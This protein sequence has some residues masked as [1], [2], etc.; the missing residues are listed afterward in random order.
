VA[1]EFDTDENNDGVIDLFKF[2]DISAT[3]I[4]YSG[5]YAE[6]ASAALST[7]TAKIVDR[8]TLSDFTAET[9][10]G[11]LEIL[12]PEHD[13]GA[14][15]GITICLPKAVSVGV[16]RFDL[17]RQ[18]GATTGIMLSDGKGHTA[19]YGGLGDKVAW[20]CWETVS[21]D[22][23]EFL[24][25]N[26]DLECVREIGIYLRS[27]KGGA[28]YIDN[29]CYETL[30]NVGDISYDAEKKTL[31]WDK[32]YG[33]TEYVVKQDGTELYRGAET[34]VILSEALDK[35]DAITC[36]VTLEAIGGEASKSKDYTLNFFGEIGAISM[37]KDTMLVYWDAVE[38]ATGYTLYLNDEEAYNGT[39]NRYQVEQGGEIIKD[40][41]AKLVVHRGE[42]EKEKTAFV[43]CLHGE[44]QSFKESVAGSENKCYIA[45]WHNLA[46]WGQFD[47]NGYSGGAE[48]G[49]TLSTG[50]WKVYTGGD[51]HTRIK[52][53]F[54]HIFSTGGWGDGRL[55]FNLPRALNVREIGSI[56]FRIKFVASEGTTWSND[57]K[58]RF[59][60]NGTGVY[61][62]GSK[63]ENVTCVQDGEWAV[64]TI[65][66]SVLSANGI[67][68]IT[69][70]SV[71]SN[72]G[73]EMDI[74]EVTYIKAS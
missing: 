72:N 23:T 30:G 48:N 57:G 10:D 13:K 32:V 5:E 4:V 58:P 8:T 22:I 68:D 3:E 36:T 50:S 45:E 7:A 24:K 29:L 17:N 12:A 26:P 65:S 47:S 41:V 61:I 46:A 70:I 67:T 9:T 39:E 49:V 34:S 54:L 28:H 16:L 37:D 44:E 62:D 56:S 73:Y 64:Y 27:T 55:T 51:M 40:W 19:Y 14:M 74:Q 69:D 25:N 42:A 11:A 66:A 43:L 15:S 6:W 18:T 38:G 71:S 60:V 33:A 63:T 35:D 1:A 21:V 53:G 20:T 2:N 31:S 59:Y 52:E